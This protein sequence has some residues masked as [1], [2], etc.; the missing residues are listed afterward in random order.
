MLLQLRVQLRKSTS[1]YMA[2]VMF[3]YGSILGLDFMESEITSVTS[4]YVGKHR[5]AVSGGQLGW[6]CL[7]V[8]SLEHSFY[9]SLP[10]FR[11]DTR[12]QA[13][14]NWF[15]IL[16]YKW[17]VTN[18]ICINLR[19]GRKTLKDKEE[20]SCFL[21]MR[22]HKRILPYSA[23]FRIQGIYM[24]GPHANARGD[25]KDVKKCV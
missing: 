15:P 17:Q 6:L 5:R 20:I 8:H 10:V 19:D 16:Y 13:D 7:A 9:S 18:F 25:N 22:S 2:V 3:L 14:V 4:V 23:T 11:Q 24:M 1:S 12:T 21:R